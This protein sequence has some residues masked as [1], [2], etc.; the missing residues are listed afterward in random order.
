MRTKEQNK[1]LAEAIK[2]K[3]RA[4]EIFSDRS[5]I[6]PESK[7]DAI[8]KKLCHR[9]KN[10]RHKQKDKSIEALAKEWGVSKNTLLC[11]VNYNLDKVTIDTCVEI[12]ESNSTESDDA[13]ET[14]IRMAV[15]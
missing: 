9:I 3:M 4:G 14:L 10:L 1:E 11:I 6:P 2:E 15:A 5:S 8:K 12:L 7:K 13:N